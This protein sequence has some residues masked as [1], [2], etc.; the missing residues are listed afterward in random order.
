MTQVAI[1]RAIG[2]GGFQEPRTGTY[3]S[4]QSDTI[5]A[6]T[7]W[8]ENLVNHDRVKLI[9]K[10]EGS[11]YAEFVNHVAAQD[12]DQDKALVEYRKVLPQASAKFEKTVVV[13]NPADLDE[14]KAEP[15]AKPAADAKKAD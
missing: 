3:I 12:G 2:D 15:K 9:E 14:K 4:S 6:F 8:V 13:E 10:V 5:V 1:V 7:E 11:V